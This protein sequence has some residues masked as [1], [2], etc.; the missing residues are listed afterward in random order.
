MKT[1]FEF[2][3]PQGFMDPDG[4]VHRDGSMRMAMALDEVEALQHPRVQ[5]N[6][7]YLPIVLLARVVTQLG[8]LTAV[9]SEV[10]ARLFAA[11]LAYLEDLYQR[12]NTPMP[13]V[14]TAVC[15]NCAHPFHL[16]VAPLA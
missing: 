9:T 5:A 4:Q 2:T 6:E 13:V 11:D 3:L 8:G 16:E 7:A 12:I 1:E 10:T 15:P 14:V